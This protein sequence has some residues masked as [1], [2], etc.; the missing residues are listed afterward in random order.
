MFL[1][2][3]PPHSV[4]GSRAPEGTVTCPRTR[5]T[6]CLVEGLACA[7]RV[8]SARHAVPEGAGAAHVN[9]VVP[10]LFCKDCGLRCRA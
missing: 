6:V 4:H 2:L 10:S 8:E 3:L 7:Q 5:Q 9:C 1:L